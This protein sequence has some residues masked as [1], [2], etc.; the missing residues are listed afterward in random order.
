MADARGSRD[1]HED[2]RK[3]LM[4]C[5]IPCTKYNYTVDSKV[6]STFDHYK[7][8]LRLTPDGKG[9]LLF[10]YRPEK[11]EKRVNDLSE[12]I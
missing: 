7:A 2:L 8:S 12:R 10:T 9:L 11:N 4:S 5:E 3:H 6:R 1:K